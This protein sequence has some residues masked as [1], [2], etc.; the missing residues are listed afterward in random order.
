MSD[1]IQ[2]IAISASEFQKKVEIETANLQYFN[3]MR[4][5]DALIKAQEY[6]ARKYVINS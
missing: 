3:Y 5:A 1:T 6:I 2:K 4:K